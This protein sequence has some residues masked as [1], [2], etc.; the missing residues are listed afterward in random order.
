[1]ERLAYN[2]WE[3]PTKSVGH[4]NGF[5]VSPAAQT[6]KGINGIEIET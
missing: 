4:L 5:G 6:L 3:K 2:L 1:M